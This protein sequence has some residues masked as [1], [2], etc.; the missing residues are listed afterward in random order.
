MGNQG[1]IREILKKVAV[2]EEQIGIPHN[3]CYYPFGSGQSTYTL[4]LEREY[5]SFAAMEEAYAKQQGAPQMRELW[6]EWTALFTDSRI[7]FLVRM[8]SE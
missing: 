8:E 1:N 3:R 2:F 4:I 7:E 6:P 5:D